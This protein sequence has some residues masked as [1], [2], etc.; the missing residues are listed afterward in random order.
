MHTEDDGFVPI[1][2]LQQR[3][4]IDKAVLEAAAELRTIIIRQG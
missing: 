4:A 1:K 2:E 3:F